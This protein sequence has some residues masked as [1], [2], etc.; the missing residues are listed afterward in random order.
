MTDVAERHRSRS[1]AGDRFGSGQT[2]SGTG[3][4]VFA[5]SGLLAH[6][7][8]RLG[9]AEL[10]TRCG[11]NLPFSAARWHAPAAIEEVEV[12]AEVTGPVLDLACGPG[13]LVRHLVERGVM[14]VGVDAAP[15]AVA[16]ARR[17]GVP[18]LLRDLWETLPLEGSWQTV[19]LFDGNIG[20][21]ARP[22]ELL[23]RCG[24][25]LT[26]GGSVVAEVGGPG[27]TSLTAE[28]R[29]EWC[30]WRSAWFPWATVAAVDLPEV[31]AA[32]GLEVVKVHQ[33]GDRSFA[34]LAS[35]PQ[36]AD[37]AA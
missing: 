34:H 31:A 6:G 37:V 35:S 33:I 17:R 12:L 8:G 24:R 28:A 29:I 20:I 19:L 26:P 3:S 1:G 21:G 25:L 22:A 15:D 16:A 36:S 4:G 23:E 9:E 2:E 7:A 14:A 11:L 13:R 32:V 10:W 18:A 5:G 30:G 27:T